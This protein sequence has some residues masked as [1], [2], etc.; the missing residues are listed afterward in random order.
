MNVAAAPLFQE[1]GLVDA[2]FELACDRKLS[3]Q[4][5]MKATLPDTCHIFTDL[6]KLALA[7]LHRDPGPCL[8]HGVRCDM[9]TGPDLMVAGFPCSPYSNQRPG[10]YTA[11]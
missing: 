1:L 9:S 6:G 11:G 7:P 4:K 10:R 3:S 8:N 2:V 5:F